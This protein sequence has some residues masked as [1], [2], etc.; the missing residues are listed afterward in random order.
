MQFILWW[1]AR[2]S[3]ERFLGRKCEWPSTYARLLAPTGTSWVRQ[4]D[5]CKALKALSPG[6][7]LK[8]KL[9]KCSLYFGGLPGARTRDP[10]IKSL[11]LYQLS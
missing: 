4:A 8:N 1:P 6:D 3:Y 10:K 2:G 5:A 7:Y 11:V 9:R